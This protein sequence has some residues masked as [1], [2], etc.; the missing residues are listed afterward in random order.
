MFVAL[1]LQTIVLA[2]AGSSLAKSAIVEMR[3]S[4]DEVALEAETTNTAALRM[5]ERLGFLKDQRLP[6]YYLSGS[7]AFRLKLWF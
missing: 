5:Y 4:C 3:K 2:N 7:D 6:K 1:L